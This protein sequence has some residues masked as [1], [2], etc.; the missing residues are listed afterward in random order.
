VRAEAERGSPANITPWYDDMLKRRTVSLAGR[1][2]W[3]TRPQNLAIAQWR[4]AAAALWR[5]LALRLKRAT[6]PAAT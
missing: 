4:A 3:L 6:K 1:D 5:A 2:I